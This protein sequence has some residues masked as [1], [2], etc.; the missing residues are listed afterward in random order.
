MVEKS[1]QSKHYY[2]HIR[3]EKPKKKSHKK[4]NEG[5]ITEEK[6]ERIIHRSLR[7]FKVYT[8]D[9]IDEATSEEVKETFRKLTGIAEG[10]MRNPTRSEEQMKTVLESKNIEYIP[11]YPVVDTHKHRYII[12]FYLPKEKKFIEIDGGYH[13]KP[14]QIKKDKKKENILKATGRKLI[15]YTNEEVRE[16]YNETLKQL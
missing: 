13:D 11:Q 2:K 3:D 12:D 8:P 5:E 1:K 15:R 6:K 14:E 10:L 4:N 7:Y 16:M 9:N